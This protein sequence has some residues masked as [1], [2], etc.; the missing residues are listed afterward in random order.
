M[1]EL[2]PALGVRSMLRKQRSRFNSGEGRRHLHLTGF[3]GV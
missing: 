2:R 3:F 1:E